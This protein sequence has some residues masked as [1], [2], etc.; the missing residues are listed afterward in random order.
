MPQAPISLTA[1]K[2][3]HASQVVNPHFTLHLSYMSSP[4]YPPI[5]YLDLCYLRFNSFPGDVCGTW[6]ETTLT[7]GPRPI[8]L[9]ATLPLR[10]PSSSSVDFRLS[11]TTRRSSLDNDHSLQRQESAAHTQWLIP[12]GHRTETRGLEPPARARVSVRSR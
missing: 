12:R 5:L 1:A 4:G 8:P 10:H 6:R 9:V 11:S 3:P 7:T 2:L